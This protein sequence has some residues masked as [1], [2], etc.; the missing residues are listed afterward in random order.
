MQFVE[1]R[2]KL[3]TVNPEFSHWKKKLKQEVKLNSTTLYLTKRVLVDNTKSENLQKIRTN[4]MS[5]KVL[6]NNKRTLIM[7]TLVGIKLTGQ[8]L[9]WHTQLTFHD[10]RNNV[11]VFSQVP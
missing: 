3:T 9:I 2:F 1:T 10:K 8:D 11:A 4:E 5:N 6:G 7:N